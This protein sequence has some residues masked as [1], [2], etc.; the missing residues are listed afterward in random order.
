MDGAKD[1]AVK[2]IPMDGCYLHVRFERLLGDKR[3]TANAFRTGWV[4]NCLKGTPN[5]SP[6]RRRGGANLRRARFSLAS[7]PLPQARLGGM[8]PGWRR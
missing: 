2:V 4:T 8:S 7:Q 1:G 3:K 6:G 5:G